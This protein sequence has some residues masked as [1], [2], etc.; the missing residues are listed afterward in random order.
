L[1]RNNSERL[2]ANIQDAGAAPPN[3]QQE[4]E[5]SFSYVVPTEFVELPSKGKY[6]PPGH[7]L[8]GQQHVEVRHMTAKEEDILT[9]RTLLK[10]GVALDRVLSNIIVNKQINLDSM[11]IGD[12]NAMI[13]AA[14]VSAYGSDYRTAVTCPSCSETSKYSFNLNESSIFDGDPENPLGVQLTESGT[15]LLQLPTTGVTTEF[16]LLTGMD[17]K[18]LVKGTEMDRKSRTGEK[19]VTRQL[20]QFVVSVNGSNNPADVNSFIDNMPSMDARQ[21]RLA[22]RLTAPNIDLTQNFV[23]PSCDH[24]QEMEVP[25]TADFFWPDR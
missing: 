14:R 19:N 16:R 13:V 2:G 5:S 21:L 3:V 1:S 25:L 12:K 17:E 9:S 10:Q 7:P 20:K 18:R 23:C 11:L 22:Y 4:T 6:Y 15:F 24:E 8:S